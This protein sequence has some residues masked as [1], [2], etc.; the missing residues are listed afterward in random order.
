[1]QRV[2]NSFKSLITSEL[3]SSCKQMTIHRY[4]SGLPKIKKNYSMDIT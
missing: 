4:H 1:M 2:E 3:V